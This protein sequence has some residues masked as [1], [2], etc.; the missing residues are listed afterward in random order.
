VS[1]AKKSKIQKIPL[2]IGP[3]KPSLGRL[4]WQGKEDNPSSKTTDD[5]LQ[6]V[7]A[8]QEEPTAFMISNNEHHC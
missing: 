4:Q 3:G 8:D 5:S 7:W 1:K 2:E 6:N